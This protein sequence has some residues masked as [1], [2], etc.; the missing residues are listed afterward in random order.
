MNTLNLAIQPRHNEVLKKVLIVQD[1][2]GNILS[3]RAIFST[4]KKYGRPTK[5]TRIIFSKRKGYH[6]SFKGGEVPR[7]FSMH[8]DSPGHVSVIRKA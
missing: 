4:K 1:E 8:Q 3:I 5:K 6:V 2:E 7:C